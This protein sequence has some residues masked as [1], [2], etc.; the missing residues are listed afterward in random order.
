MFKFLKLV[1]IIKWLFVENK[2]V[3]INILICDKG[4]DI[5]SHLVEKNLWKSFKCGEYDTVYN[6]NAKFYNFFWFAKNKQELPTPLKIKKMKIYCQYKNS[7]FYSYTYQGAGGG[8][9]WG[10]GQDKKLR[11]VC[12]GSGWVPKVE[13][14]YFFP[15]PCQFAKSVKS[16]LITP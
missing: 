7:Y 8:G 13:E 5:D 1:D 10:G 14:T 6:N 2:W 16:S 12:W 3:A 15:P 4:I 11:R 9:G